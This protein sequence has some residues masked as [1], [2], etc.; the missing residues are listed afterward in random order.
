MK[1]VVVNALTQ[2][3]FAL[4]VAFLVAVPC[5]VVYLG[6]S[7]ITSTIIVNW[8]PPFWPIL[9]LWGVCAIAVWIAFRVP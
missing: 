8:D 7:A 4:V 5:W 9:G 6:L 1:Q 3:T 2:V